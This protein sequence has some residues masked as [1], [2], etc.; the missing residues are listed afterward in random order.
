MCFPGVFRLLLIALILSGCANAADPE[1]WRSDEEIP[2]ST[3]GEVFTTRLLP[4]PPAASVNNSAV[5]VAGQLKNF[6]MKAKMHLDVEL[7]TF[8]DA[9]GVAG[10]GYD[11]NS[12]FPFTQEDNYSPVNIGQLKH[13]VS[14]FHKRF[15][16]IGY[17]DYT[18]VTP[19]VDDDKIVTI[20]L[21]KT[22]FL[23]DLRRY[24]D[25][26]ADGLPD[27][28]EEHYFGSISVDPSDLH[29]G[30]IIQWYFDNKEEVI[31][32][33]GGGLPRP[34][35][36]DED[37]DIYQSVRFRVAIDEIDANGNATPA[38]RN[39]S[40]ND[41]TKT[42]MG[43]GVIVAQFPFGEIG[44]FTIAHPTGPATNLSYAVSIEPLDD[45]GGA[46]EFYTH[47]DPG[48]PFNPPVVDTVEATQNIQW[49][50]PSI[51]ICEVGGA[52][53]VGELQPSDPAPPY[54]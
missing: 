51:D 30:K 31:T 36:I 16:D 47:F 11:V 20:G 34:A 1:W 7:A 32:I 25:S 49:Y 8:K 9:V 39:I 21:L 43:Y 6:A 27:F 18:S 52:G 54:H 37:G 46:T 2:G 17:D 23:F 33:G 53:K 15:D 12:L 19:H 14:Q 42:I 3:P 10:A 26:D 40:V 45:N 4:G 38:T 35:G 44:Q 28:W 5:A 41:Q 50:F 24:G 13:V 29:G 22:V 48:T